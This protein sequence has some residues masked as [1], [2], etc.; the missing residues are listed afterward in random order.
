M[1]AL[2]LATVAGSGCDSSGEEFVFTRPEG[3]VQPGPVVPD[4]QG[5]ATL[6]LESTLEVDDPV[7]AQT[8][9]RTVSTVQFS[10][11]NSSGARI[12]T[13]SP[14]AKSPQISVK[15]PLGSSQVQIDYLDNTGQLQEVWGSPIPPLTLNSEFV[16][17]Q[18]NPDPT[19]NVTR[20]A[21]EGPTSFPVGIPTQFLARATYLGGATRLVTN[22]ASFTANGAAVMPGG[23]L[24]QAGPGR[25]A[26]VARFGGRTSAEFVSEA[27]NISAL[28]APFFADATGQFVVN[29]LEI[30]GFG[31]TAQ[32]RLFSDFADGQRREVTRLATY[33]STPPG[34]VT[35][36]ALGQVTAVDAGTTTLTGLFQGRQGSTR[37][38]VGNDFFTTVF[39]N[40]RV[41]PNTI[42]GM[43]SNF[44][45]VD[46]NIDGRT[47]IVGLPSSGSG[48]DFTRLAIHLGNGDGTFQPARFVTLPFTANASAGA[49]LQFLSQSTNRFVAVGKSDQSLLAI[50]S[51]SGLSGQISSRTETL[52]VAPKQLMSAIADQLL[53]RGQ[54]ER[55]YRL[56]SSVSGPLRLL[57]PLS[58][59]DI[60]ADEFVNAGG[61]FVFHQQLARSNSNFSSAL[62]FLDGTTLNTRANLGGPFASAPISDV[63]VF[64]QDR[65]A[66][67]AGLGGSGGLDV[68]LATLGS[69]SQ[70]SSSFSPGGNSTLTAF[71]FGSSR[72]I[73]D[74][75]A[76][77]GNTPLVMSFAAPSRSPSA[78]T[79]Y[80]TGTFNRF[81]TGDLTGDG[82]FD[83]ISWQNGVLTLIE[84]G[85][86]LP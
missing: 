21:V 34:I 78:L 71:E 7:L 12:F 35:A 31:G 23:F 72:R 64:E 45:V 42:S 65:R 48:T 9:K 11:F 73:F 77:G 57:T 86:T 50:V 27:R 82:T 10:T 61:G 33:A 39:T 51:F 44:L 70:S 26:I 30:A 75:I 55:L 1:G 52:P 56:A 54:D 6:T 53:I 2:L 5:E 20:V 17:R 14:I 32:M 85:T 62:R 81:E 46:F 4:P 66:Q 40:F 37:I 28:G 41:L 79:G 83:L 69:T 47:D 36:N 76:S 60:D 59:P 29:S 3:F 68:N 18:P 8:I 16:I 63:V 13:S 24:T 84:L 19:T 58:Y 38:T 25:N 74:T 43:S 80:P 22:S 49:R 67:F 15:V